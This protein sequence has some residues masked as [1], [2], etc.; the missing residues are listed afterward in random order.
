MEGILIAILWVIIGFWINYKRNWYA[1]EDVPSLSCW[2]SVC[3]AP[4]N[5]IIVL[6]KVFVIKPWNKDTY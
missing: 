6:F 4:I 1:Q 3:F 5:L 2:T